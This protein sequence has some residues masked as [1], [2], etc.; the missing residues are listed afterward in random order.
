MTGDAVELQSW[1][2]PCVHHAGRAASGLPDMRLE[3]H[4]HGERFPISTRARLALEDNTGQRFVIVSAD[5]IAITPTIAEPVAEAVATNS[6]VSR[7]SR[8]L[9]TATHTHYGPEFRPDK[10][11]F[12]NIPAEYAEKIP[13]GCEPTRRR[14]GASDR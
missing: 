3:L 14:A 2:R 1:S 8:L 13:A 7:V 4:L 12:F 6:T 11:V 5:L 10:Q 9:L